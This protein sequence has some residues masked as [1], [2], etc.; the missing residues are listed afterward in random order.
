MLSPKL[1]ELKVEKTCLEISVGKNA[2]GKSL[3]KL[4]YVKYGSRFNDV[5]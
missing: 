4:F 3:E 2:F 1:V 5:F